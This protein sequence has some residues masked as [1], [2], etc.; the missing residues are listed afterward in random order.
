MTLSKKSALAVFFAL[1]LA[2]N[3]TAALMVRQFAATKSAV[4]VGAFA[5]MVLVV[6]VIY[7]LLLVR[8]GLQPWL[9]L[10]AIAL[11][12]LLRASFVL[13]PLAPA[14]AGIASACELRWLRLL[15]GACGD[16]WL[17]A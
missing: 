4:A 2:I 17:R 11:V 12:G 1:A 9:T 7:Y 13:P 10:P 8:P 16:R 3:V 14:R 5:D 15:C 6:P